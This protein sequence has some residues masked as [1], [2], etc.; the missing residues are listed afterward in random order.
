MTS[1]GK[2]NVQMLNKW[3]M[4]LEGKVRSTKKCPKINI[5]Y[6]KIVEIILIMCTFLCIGT[7][8]MPTYIISYK[9]QCLKRINQ[10]F[11]CFFL[12]EMMNIS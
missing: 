10:V 4:L 2:M 1:E 11:W 6:N 12:S 7:R 3:Q 5:S 8:A 9:F